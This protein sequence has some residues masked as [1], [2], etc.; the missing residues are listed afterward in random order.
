MLLSITDK[1]FHSNQSFCSMRN[2]KTLPETRIEWV[3]VCKGVL[4]VLMVCGHTT[5]PFGKYI[6]LFH[7]PAFMFLT[8]YV[9]KA[10]PSS[11]WHYFVKRFRGILIPYIFWNSLYLALYTILKNKHIYLFFDSEYNTSF[12]SFFHHLTTTD[13]DGATWFLPV[14][15]TISI[16]YRILYVIT[17]KLKLNNLAPFV[18]LTIGIIGFYLCHNG[19]YLPYLFDL[20]LYGLF[21]YG[22]GQLFQREHI[23]ETG[24]P[25]R[26]MVALCIFVFYVFGYLYPELMMNWP[27]RDFVGLFENII[28]T[29]CGLFI[30]YHIA[31]GITKYKLLC[32]SFSFL[33]RH[34][35]IILILHFVI[36]RLFFAIFIVLGKLPNDYLLNLVPGGEWPLQ[37]LECLLFTLL[38]CGLISWVTDHSRILTFLFYGRVD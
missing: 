21:Y 26:E 16:C 28:S 17:D 24:L 11:I 14:I 9:E 27:T 25:P 19:L 1:E 3:D 38:I 34:T 36:F 33:G 12:N 23:L 30:C 2:V 29:I 5:S 31:L 10:T 20:S 7:M 8:G 4:I 15:F 35:I 37:W 22:L 32:T 6:Y 18:A 13:L